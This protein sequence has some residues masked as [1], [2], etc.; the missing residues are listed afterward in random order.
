[1]LLYRQHAYVK[2]NGKGICLSDIEMIDKM[3]AKSA[4]A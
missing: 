2:S 3:G 4:D 1:M